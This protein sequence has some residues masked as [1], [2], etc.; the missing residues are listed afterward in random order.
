MNST[1]RQALPGLAVLAVLAKPAQAQATGP[2]SAV[3]TTLAP[4]ELVPSGWFSGDTHEH[5]QLCDDTAL[6]AQDILAR[7]EVEDL[8]VASILI[9][10]R[11]AVLPFTEFIC[12]VTQ[13]GPPV[14]APRLVQFGVETSGLSCS[15]WGHLIGL[16]IGPAQARVAFGSLANGDCANM[17]GLGLPGDGSGLYNT[18][19]AEHFFTAP[20]AVCGY[21]HTVWTIGLYHPDGHD[22]NTDLLASGFTNDARFLDPGQHLAVPNVDRLFGLSVPPNSARFFFPLLGAADAALGNVQFIETIVAGPTIGFPTTPPAHWNALYYKLLSAGVRVGL[23]GGSDRACFPTEVGETPVRTHVKLDGPLT[24]RA[25][26]DGL[27]DGRASIADGNTLFVR[28][29]IDG[30]EVG[31]DVSASPTTPLSDVRVL[32]RSTEPLTDTVELVVNGSVARSQPVTLG[33][34][35]ERTFLFDDVV[36]GSSSWIAARLGSQRAHTAALYAIVGGHPIADPL[37]AEYWMLWCD[38]VT[39]TIVDHPE[40]A[41]FGLQEGEV[42]AEVAKARRSFK[43]LRDQTFVPGSGITRHGLSVPACRGPLTIGAMEPAHVGATFRL[44]CTNAPPSARGVLVLST[45]PLGPGGPSLAPFAAPRTMLG[46]HPV[47]STRSGYAEVE[48]GPIPAGVPE[49]HAQ[50]FWENPLD[51]RGSGGE[52]RSTSDRLRLVVQ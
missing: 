39:K 26:T 9:W 43:T 20:G 45:R 24:Y 44:T 52:A 5:I 22:W 15:L 34:A 48:A 33:T 17:P 14:T 19:V 47:R 50:F 16:G 28:L 7:M 51:C 25:W 13:P 11:S 38:L 18:P 27:A 3:P 46:S 23:A 2:T 12:N 31:S 30:K 49:V 42:L 41:W 29:T 10:Q 40:R 32:V 36:L 4:V 37:W 21:A 1:L 6:T 8:D 35:G